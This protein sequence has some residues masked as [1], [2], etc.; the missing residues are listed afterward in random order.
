MQGALGV[1]TEELC[2]Q[3]ARQR[4]GEQGNDDADERKVEETTQ[5]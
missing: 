5:P 4:R 3:P 1:I 2:C